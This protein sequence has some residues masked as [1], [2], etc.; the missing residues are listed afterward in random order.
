M[1]QTESN[2]LQKRQKSTKPDKEG[3]TKKIHAKYDL[4]T[5]WIGRSDNVQDIK[6]GLNRKKHKNKNEIFLSCNWFISLFVFFF[7]YTF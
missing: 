4:E 1:Y 2:Q 3:D 7:L 6:M 5:N